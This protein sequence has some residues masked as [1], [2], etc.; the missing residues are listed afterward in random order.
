[1]I[2]GV[3]NEYCDFGSGT[4]TECSY[5]HTAIFSSSGDNTITFDYNDKA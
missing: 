1:M 4:V 5:E 2:D 3:A